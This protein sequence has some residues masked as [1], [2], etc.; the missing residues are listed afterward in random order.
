MIRVNRLNN[1]EFVINC[2]LIEFI[3]ETPD[4]VITLT[5]GKKIVVK[6]SIDEIIDKVIKFK[7]NIFI[8]RLKE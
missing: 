1:T 2:E 4:T 6:E 8:Y 5:T 7:N 3:E